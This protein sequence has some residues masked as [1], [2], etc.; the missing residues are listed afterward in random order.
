MKRLVVGLS[1]VTTQVFAQVQSPEMQTLQ[2]EIMA[3]LNGKLQCNMQIITLQQK[4]VNMEAQIKGLR[5]K[6]EP[7]K[8]K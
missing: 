3:Q 5:D 6:Y 8:V 2:N 7:E 4:L 1:L